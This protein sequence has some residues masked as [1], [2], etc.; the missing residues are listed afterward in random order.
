M[1][2]F[3][4]SVRSRRNLEG[5]H[6]DLKAVMEKALQKNEI[7]FVVYEGLRSLK[8]QR[9]L[10]VNGASSTMNSRHL[11]GHAVDI[12][13]VVGKQVRFD[14]PLYHRLAKVIKETAVEMGVPIVWGGDWKSF[15]D[16]PHFELNR[17]T[18]P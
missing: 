13:P 9:E 15:P 14:W 6:P 12:A 7:D 8:R 10:V 11:T 18:Y 17:K 4:F 2:A 16:G 1:M 5:I 3:R